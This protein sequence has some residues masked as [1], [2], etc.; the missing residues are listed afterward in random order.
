MKIVGNLYWYPENGV[1]DC[2]TYLFD[3]Q[4]RILI[5]PGIVV[6]MDMLV[7]GLQ[8][9]GIEPEDV[10]VIINT[11]YHPDHSGANVA[12]KRRFGAE[13]MTYK[14]AK[15][16]ASKRF[17][18]ELK[19]NDVTLEIITTPGHSPESISMYWRDAQALICGDLVFAYGVGRVDI[20]GGNAEELKSSI[21]KISRLDLEYLLP[22]HGEI[23]WGKINID[24]NFK[25]IRK[26]YFNLL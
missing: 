9:D 11:H 17:G 7:K 14:G 15:R 1:M 21:E 24:R 23:L 25:Y 18:N 20:G 10:D 19:L 8:E 16:K 3:E 4:I 22:G 13:I 2:N 26:A 12:W 6:Y 5:D